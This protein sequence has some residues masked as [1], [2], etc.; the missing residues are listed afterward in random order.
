MS[1]PGFAVARPVTTVMIT[2]IAVL[3]GLVALTRIPVDLL[4]NI[5][6]PSLNIRVN[7]RNASPQTVEELITRVVEQAVAATPGLEEMRSVSREGESDVTLSFAWGTDLDAAANDVRDRLFSEVDDLPD[8]AERPRLRKFDSADLPIMALGIASPIDPV[9]LRRIIDNR[10][11]YRIQQVAGVASTEIWGGPEREIQV[12]VDLSQVQALSLSLVDISQALQQANRNLP[13]GAIEVGQRE[14][15]LRTPGRLDDL[16]ELRQT[17]VTTRNG[18]PVTVA[19]IATVVDTQQRENRLIRINGDAGVRMAVRK[20]SDANTVDVSRRVLAEVAKLN[21]EYPQLSIRPFFDTAGFIERSIAN[22]SRSLLYGSGLAVLVLLLFLGNPRATL[23]VA[24]AIPVSLVA[25]FALIFFN[26][27]TINLMTLGG[28]ALGVGLMVDSAIVVLDN[29]L[30]R[31][32]EG[33]E[34]RIDSGVNGANEIAAAIVASTLTT[35][36]IFIPMLFARELAGQLFRELAIVVAFALICALLVALTL[37]PMLTARLVS[38]RPTPPWPWLGR[39]IA[40]IGRGF[41]RVQDGYRDRLADSL[42]RPRRILAATALALVGAVMAVPMLGTEFMP[43]SDEGEVRVDLEMPLGTP[44]EVLDRQ[45]RRAEAIIREEVPELLS[46]VTSVETEGGAETDIQVEL[47]PVS[48]RDRSSSEVAAALREAV[49]GLPDTTVRVRVRQPFFLRFLSGNQSEGENLSIEVRGYDFDVINR[50]TGQVEGAIKDI[51]GITDVRLPRTGGEPQRLIDIDR[52][53]AADLGVSVESVGRTVEAAIAGTTAGYFLDQGDEVRILLKLANNRTIPPDAILDLPVPTSD[54]DTVPLGAVASLTEARGPVQIDREDQQRLNLIY[55]NISGRDL[56][57][58]VEDVQTALAGIAVPSNYD[59][60]LAGEFEEQ[61]ETFREMGINVILALL[62]VYMVMA[63][64][65]ESLRDPFIVMITVPLALIGVVAMLLL[66]GTTLNAQSLVGCLMLIGIVVNNAILIVDQ[67]NLLQRQG[68]SPL[69]AVR[70][71]GRRRLRPIMMT[72]AT[73]ILALTPLAI[74]VGE[75]S[76]SQAPLARAVIGGL[77]SSTLITLIV[78][79][80]VYAGFH[81][82]WP[83]A[84]QGT[85]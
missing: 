62:L 2:L 27:Y 55:A 20:Q 51:P 53:R 73:T 18:T 33:G 84:R 81:R 22:V 38:A 12:N 66:T 74:G 75:G 1:L 28:L 10:L 8:E 30:R 80:V 48:Q 83:P 19:D 77:L 31:R 78:I 49:T 13:A 70:E 11:L 85:Y 64:L 25:T 35:L 6:A 16:D 52:S 34:N 72:A 17:M 69:D 58:V 40:A 54:G 14:I 50:L 79:P 41:N 43:A 82:A 32:E 76:E 56:G 59:I 23:V 67:A 68:D 65:Y 63:C 24:T 60:A 71:A 45:T 5:E 26:G 15:T 36:A 47:P 39:L 7:Y 3:L 46:M 9:E 37:V 21:A 4:P 29:I 42:Q 44:L 61:V 57:S